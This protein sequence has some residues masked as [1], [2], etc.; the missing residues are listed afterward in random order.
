MALWKGSDV[1]GESVDRDW[2]APCE[3]KPESAHSNGGQARHQRAV[4]NSDELTRLDV[5]RRMRREGVLQRWRQVGPG[6]RGWE[7]DWK[8]SL[9]GINCSAS[10]VTETS[11]DELVQGREAEGCG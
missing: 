4:S 6:D 9:G 5:Q 8:T 2:A 3:C 11:T 1:G 7:H 10:H